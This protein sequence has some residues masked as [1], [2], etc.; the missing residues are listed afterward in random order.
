MLTQ[1]VMV[2]WL[3]SAGVSDL[4]RADA[5]KGMA[6]TY[7]LLVADTVIVPAEGKLAGK[8]K[9]RILTLS[10]AKSW[11]EVAYFFKVRRSHQ[12]RHSRRPCAGCKGI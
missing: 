7:A 10:C 4:H 1:H 9:E 11:T 5:D 2:Q 6:S 8:E 12:R 3:F